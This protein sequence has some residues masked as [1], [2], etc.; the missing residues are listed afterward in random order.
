MP[1][2]CTLSPAQ[3]DTICRLREERN[4]THGQIALIVGCSVQQ[5]RW[6]CR[7]RGAFGP[8]DLA[9]YRDGRKPWVTP[10]TRGGRTIVPFTD[11]E[12][13]RLLAMARA[14][15]NFSAIGR[16]FGRNPVSIRTHVQILERR[17]AMREEIEA[18]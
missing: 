12:D 3:I 15:R 5:S 13:E 18:C 17:Q 8:R 11:E 2:P 10:T 9:R 6:H 7:E 14:G 4:L 1:R 16:A